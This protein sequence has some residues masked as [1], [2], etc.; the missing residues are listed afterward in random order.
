M[1][2]DIPEIDLSQFLDLFID[3]GQG[4]LRTLNQCML[5]LE[6]NPDDTKT[7]ETMFRA[8]HSLKGSSAT[9]GYETLSS[10]AHAAEDVLHKLRQGDWRLTPTLVDLLFESID[11][12]QKL[13]NDAAAGDRPKSNAYVTNT[14]EK[15]RGYKPEDADI[16]LSKPIDETKPSIAAQQPSQTQTKM[17]RVDVRHLDSL[18]NVVTE[19]IINRSLLSRM[20]QYY[21]LKPLEDALID[22]SRLLT[23]LQN[24]VLTMRMVPVKQVFGRFPRM[25]R[26]LLKK[27]GKIAQLIIAGQD[28]ELDR[29]ALERLSDP[30]IHI[31]RNAIDH[32]LET[33]YEREKAGKP[34]SGTLRLSARRERD[35]VTIE[36][37]DDGRGMNAQRIT[38]A[39][40]QRGLFTSEEIAEMHP[41][42]ILQ[43]ICQPGFSLNKEVTT[44]SGRGVGMGVVKHTVETLRG[45]LEIETQPGQ[46]SSIR[47]S[48]PVML[49][50]VDATIIRVGNEKYALPAAQ[51]E[52]IIE[53]NPARIERIGDQQII[54]RESGVL[55]VRKLSNLLHTYNADPE[56]RFAL[57]VQHNGEPVALRVDVV[58][59]HKEIVVKPLP[60]ALHHIPGL[61]G[62]TVLGEGQ[63]VLI[64]DSR[65]LF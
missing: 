24:A 15:L 2:D 36:V 26:D 55:P 46:G 17:I 54:N 53:I 20:G 47:I 35:M 44:V 62:V 38:D 39:A 32:G 52:R 29:A 64:L 31:L 51:I 8:A 19:M 10:T 57:I 23:Q 18:L 28:V 25:V 27:E 58:L 63:A 5:T 12:L 11:F 56:P 16:V 4:H 21:K 34:P 14:I 49:A 65:D 41:Q 1:T 45:T 50:M 7:L 61:T 30:L 48:V 43:L 3:E 37:S 13:L 60:P 6:S 33:P 40:V 22:H 42:Q 59:A 9:M